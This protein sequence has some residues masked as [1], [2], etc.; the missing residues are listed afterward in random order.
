MIRDKAYQLCKG[1]WK[2]EARAILQSLILGFLRVTE[3]E[4]HSSRN[5]THF[6]TVAQSFRAQ[7][8]GYLVVDRDKPKLEETYPPLRWADGLTDEERTSLVNA[9]AQIA[10]LNRDCIKSFVTEF[11]DSSIAIDPYAKFGYQV[12]H[13]RT[14]LELLQKDLADEVINSFSEHPAFSIARSCARTIQGSVSPVELARGVENLEQNIFASGPL[15]S[16]KALS[17]VLFT[18]PSAAQEKIL[19]DYL[20]A[21]LSVRS[22]LAIL[23]ELV[24]QAI[25]YNKLPVLSD[26]NIIQIS[27]V[28]SHSSGIG[29]QCFCQPDDAFGHWE[30]GLALLKSNEKI[31]QELKPDLC[32]VETIEFSSSPEVGDLYKLGLR[33][34]DSNLNPYGNLLR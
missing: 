9:H 25:L 4:L 29:V 3:S 8:L 23:D 26:D 2:S 19:F 5:C 27:G 6:G 32:R 18:Y 16:M 12:T 20:C 33:T 15:R 21:L 24:F 14:G 34:I 31:L 13:V 7:I 17:Q 30:L 11:P 28:S 10:A 1:V 22:S